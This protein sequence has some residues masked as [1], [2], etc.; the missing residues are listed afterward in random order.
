MRLLQLAQLLTACLGALVTS[1]LTP[2]CKIHDHDASGAAVH[3]P[4]QVLPTQATS[5]W[6]AAIGGSDAVK[7]A[8]TTAK[9]ACKRRFEAGANDTKTSA[10]GTSKEHP[11]PYGTNDDVPPGGETRLR[12]RNMLQAL[13]GAVLYPFGPAAGNGHTCPTY[14]TCWVGVLS[15]G[16]VRT[17]SLRSLGTD[18]LRA[19]LQRHRPGDSLPPQ[20]AW[21]VRAVNVRMRVVGYEIVVPD[22]RWTSVDGDDVLVAQY[23]LTQPMASLSPPPSSLA[24]LA[25]A[26]VASMAGS[27]ATAADATKGYRLEMRLEELYPGMLYQ[28]PAP[29]VHV[30]T[31]GLHTAGNVYLGGR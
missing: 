6:L 13:T 15:C 18:L 5:E 17:E 22:V 19:A 7:A 3:S 21:T 14:H 4:P 12:G 31:L 11:P 30:D 28:W 8:Y 23:T 10:G 2:N 1:G 24:T 26:A 9:A 25:A 20:G 27:T 16:R 29:A